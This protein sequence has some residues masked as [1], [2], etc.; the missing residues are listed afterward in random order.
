VA[1]TH[2]DSKVCVRNA[3]GTACSEP[4]DLTLLPNDDPICYSSGVR[5]GGA[6]AYNQQHCGPMNTCILATETCWHQREE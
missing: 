2:K 4:F 1:F 6:C 5:P 3:A